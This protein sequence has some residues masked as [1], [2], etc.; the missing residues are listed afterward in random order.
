MNRNIPNDVVRLFVKELTEPRGFHAFSLVNKRVSKLCLA[1]MIQ[2]FM[3]MKFTITE[4]TTNYDYPNHNI[5]RQ[6]S[7][8]VSKRLHGMQRLW[9]NDVL[10]EEINW[11]HG[12]KDG[13][14]KDFHTESGRLTQIM[15]WS[16]NKRHG[17]YEAYWPTC[18]INH[19][20]MWALDRRHGLST[21]YDLYGRLIR[22]TIWDH[23][24]VIST[25]EY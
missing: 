15:T 3:E 22:E 4:E 5:Y 17:P 25:K 1:P 9:R 18:S 20:I 8:Y 16:N 12:V 19:R 23:G 13:V 14:G 7:K 10:I 6:V 11:K 21:T 2:R 24:I